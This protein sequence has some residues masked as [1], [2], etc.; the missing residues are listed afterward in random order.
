VF[1]VSCCVLRVAG[2]VLRVACCVLRVACCVL[3]VACCVLLV[4]CCVLRNGR[5]V[6]I[7]IFTTAMK[8]PV[9]LLKN[10]W[11]GV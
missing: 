3:R 2:C 9:L 5:A 6:L 4:V 8:L 7:I 11:K 1:G 10:S